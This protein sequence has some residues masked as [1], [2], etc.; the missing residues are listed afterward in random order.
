MR[1][2]YDVSSTWFRHQNSEN[3]QWMSIHSQ[4]RLLTKFS[5]VHFLNWV[6]LFITLTF[7]ILPEQ[8]GIGRLEWT[9][10]IYTHYSSIGNVIRI[11]HKGKECICWKLLQ[12]FLPKLR[13]YS[14]HSGCFG[15]EIN[16]SSR[17]LDSSK[18]AWTFR[19]LS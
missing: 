2:K 12:N 7:V 17:K 5:A 9:S 1:E 15:A 19:F 14:A 13:L 10:F 11:I 4:S 8:T 6:S 18:S 16:F 3:D